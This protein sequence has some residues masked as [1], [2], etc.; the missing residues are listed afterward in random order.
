MHISSR[1]HG[2][3]YLDDSMKGKA[4]PPP[5]DLGWKGFYSSKIS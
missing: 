1:S 5:Q 4:P 3:A 2:P